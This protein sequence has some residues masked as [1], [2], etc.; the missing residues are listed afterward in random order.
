VLV[1]LSCRS[2]I[3]ERR[4]TLFA[5]GTIRLK[6]ISG[7][8]SAISLAELG[9]EELAGYL[10]RLRGEDLSEVDVTR[11]SVSGEWI[12][13]CLLELSLPGT[14]PRRFELQRYDSLPLPL[15]RVL[16]VVDELTAQ[17]EAVPVRSQ[18]PRDYAPRAGDILERTDGVLFEIRGYTDD[19][20]GIELQGVEWSSR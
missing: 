20:K 13:E 7:G 19:G 8:V 1:E 11:L 3:A 15:W 2:E 6:E 10:H 9:P 12:E 17:A 16:S 14:E 18:L 5:N 4:T